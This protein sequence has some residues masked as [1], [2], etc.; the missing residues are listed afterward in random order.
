MI[1]GNIGDALPSSAPVLVREIYV[2]GAITEGPAVM[3]VAAGDDLA[4]AA[5]QWESAELA[6]KHLEAALAHVRSRL[7][8]PLTVQVRPDLELAKP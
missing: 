1:L 4:I 7:A 6:E 8:L 5:L 2:G 3:I